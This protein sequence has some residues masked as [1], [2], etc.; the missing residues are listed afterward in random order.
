[1]ASMFESWPNT[2]NLLFFGFFLFSF[3][4]K[5]VLDLSMCRNR[6]IKNYWHEVESYQKYC[7]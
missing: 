1:M 5:L 2:N 6:H 7:S 4:L 3:F